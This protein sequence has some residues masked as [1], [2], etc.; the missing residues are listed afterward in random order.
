[1]Y[2][3][4]SPAFAIIA[5]LHL[6][7]VSLVRYNHL[8]KDLTL[9]ELTQMVMQ[10]ARGKGFGTNKKDINVPEKIALIHSEI[11]EAYDAYRHKKVR[12]NKKRK[13]DWKNLNEAHH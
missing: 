5:R 9:K 12:G 7:L 4:I 6:A 8:V 10:Q 1:M 3:L 2:T 13:W 11:S